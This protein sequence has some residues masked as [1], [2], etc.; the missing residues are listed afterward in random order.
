MTLVGSVLSVGLLIRWLLAHQAVGD[1]QLM[2]LDGAV[3]ALTLAALAY[4]LD[5]VTKPYED[6]RHRIAEAVRARRPRAVVCNGYPEQRDMAREIDAIMRLLEEH[7]EDPN[8]GPVYLHGGERAGE[9]ADTFVDDEPSLTDERVE[10][11]EPR[12]DV[13]ASLDSKTPETA[14]DPLLDSIAPND[15]YRPVFVDYVQALRE[16]NRGG[17]IGTYGAFVE[18]LAHHRDQLLEQHPGY[19]VI[20]YVEVA[21]LKIKP[22][23]IPLS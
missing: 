8:L 23:L 13:V 1:N 19:E 7:M 9:R 15:P 2:L 3:I 11:E 22:R 21:T 12:L 6:M 18:D 17:E 10:E 14:P 4:A 16:A 5:K 20:F